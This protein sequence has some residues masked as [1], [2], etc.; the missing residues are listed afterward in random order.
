MKNLSCVALF[1]PLLGGCGAFDL[2]SKVVGVGAPDGVTIRATTPSGTHLVHVPKEKTEDWGGT[3]ARYDADEGVVVESTEPL[4]EM[5]GASCR[6]SETTSMLTVRPLRG[7]AEVS[8]SG[9][10]GGREEG[11]VELG[12][13]VSEASVESEGSVTARMTV[14]DPGGACEWP[15]G[16]PEELTVTWAL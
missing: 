12:G 9:L 2:P 16:V 6:G 11:L 13:N 7:G 1:V 15:E 4:L 10:R 14:D 8:L 5:L 3:A